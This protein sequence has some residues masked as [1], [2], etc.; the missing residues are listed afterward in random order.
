MTF[1]LREH[2]LPVSANSLLVCKGLKRPTRKS[3]GTEPPSCLSNPAAAVLCPLHRV[4]AS[5]FPATVPSFP[6]LRPLHRLLPSYRLLPFAVRPA[7]N[8][9][10]QGNG[11]AVQSVQRGLSL[12]PPCSA[13]FTGSWRPVF[14]PL[15][16]SCAASS[17]LALSVA[18][19]PGV[20]C[21]ASVRRTDSCCLLLCC[22]RLRLRQPHWLLASCSLSP[23]LLLL[24]SAPFV[25]FPP[26][27]CHSPVYSPL[28]VVLPFRTFLPSVLPFP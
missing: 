21:T 3:R 27:F 10:V 18:L 11:V 22:C 12:L 6:A 4:L 24:S 17:A 28:P 15:C 1:S 13:N 16:Q 23:V 5:C 14:P 26:P 8:S 19:G 20:H 7:S 2:S 25:C 9:E